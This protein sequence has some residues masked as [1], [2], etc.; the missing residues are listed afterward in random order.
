MNLE[1]DS[2]GFIK[3]N[4]NYLERKSSVKVNLLGVDQAGTVQ[5]MESSNGGENQVPVSG[6]LHKAW[7]RNVIYSC[8]L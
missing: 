3:L 8:N 5:V 1:L 6:N 2:N 4:H 7:L